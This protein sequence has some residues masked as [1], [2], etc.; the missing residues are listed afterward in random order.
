MKILKGGANNA[1]LPITYHLYILVAFAIK[2]ISRIEFKLVEKILQLFFKPSP[3]EIEKK[4][5]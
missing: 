1:L 3:L 4:N 2:W 5:P